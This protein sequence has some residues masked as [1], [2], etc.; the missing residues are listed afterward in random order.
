MVAGPVLVPV[1]VNLPATA[2]ILTATATTIFPT[3]PSTSVPVDHSTPFDPASVTT[4]TYTT[5]TPAL[6]PTTTVDLRKVVG[7]TV[8]AKVITDTR[9]RKSVVYQ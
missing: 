1:P 5:V 4:T 3:N 6:L 2:P 7:S 9:D 8:H